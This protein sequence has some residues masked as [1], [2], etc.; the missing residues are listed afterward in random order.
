WCAP[1][2]RTPRPDRARDGTSRAASENLHQHREGEAPGSCGEYGIR[3]VCD[4]QFAICDL[5]SQMDVLAHSNRKSQI[6]NRKSQ[7]PPLA[8]TIHGMALFGRTSA[9][10]QQRALAWGLWVR[11]R[12]PFAIASVVVGLFSLIEFGANLV[13]GIA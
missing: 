6:A 12:N 11:R 3:G 1:A 4:F 9:R 13:F 2:R 10:E 7:I 8:P 5:R